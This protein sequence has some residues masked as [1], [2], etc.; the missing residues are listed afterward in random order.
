[1]ATYNTVIKKRNT[2]NDE[3]DSIL[4][5]TTA[6]N[7]L[8]DESGGTLDS[9]LNDFA[10]LERR[11]QGTD[12]FP[13]EQTSKTVE[14]EKIEDD[15]IVSIYPQADTD[16]TWTVESKGATYKQLTVQED[17]TNLDT[18]NASFDGTLTT[19]DKL[20]I[21]SVEIDITGVTDNS[22]VIDKTTP[23]Q[24]VNAA[25]D[26]SGNGGRKLVRLS[27]GWLVCAVY[28]ANDKLYIKVSKNDGSTWTDLCYIT[29]GYVTTFSL[30]SDGNILY[31]LCAN[32]GY[33]RLWKIDAISQSNTD[34]STNNTQLDSIE[35]LLFAEIRFI[36]SSSIKFTDCFFLSHILSFP[37]LKNTL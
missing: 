13:S 23:V 27:N 31:L 9:H 34:I 37:S 11:Y 4:P 2:A 16:G 36:P 8:T 21:N 19:A 30:V 14:H 18:F 26:T 22:V 10:S 24:V 33:V 17:I 15:T 5:I 12:T 7:V 28:N 6:E 29:Y 20:N 1:M 25:Y 3:W 32:M 35:V